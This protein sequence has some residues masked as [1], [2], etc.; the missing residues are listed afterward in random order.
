VRFPR[1]PP[2]FFDAP[3]LACG[4]GR[5]SPFQTRT[6]R[7]RPLAK[8]PG[9]CQSLPHAST[10]LFSGPLKNPGKARFLEDT[11]DFRIEGRPDFFPPRNPEIG[12]AGGAGEQVRNRGLQM[13][14]SSSRHRSAG[15]DPERSCA[16]DSALWRTLN[17]Q[18]LRRRQTWQCSAGCSSSRRVAYLVCS[19]LQWR[20]LWRL[21]RAGS[22]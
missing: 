15:Q 17:W 6:A 12:G 11:P 5:R 8:E 16:C 20:L 4:K 9:P 21:S 1:R 18:T 14:N 3:S 10:S 2:R 13:Q 7:A 19:N 22:L